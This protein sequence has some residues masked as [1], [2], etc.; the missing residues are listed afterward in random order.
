MIAWAKSKWEKAH[1]RKTIP[2]RLPNDMLLFT[3]SDRERI[4]AL[5]DRE[6]RVRRMVVHTRS[7]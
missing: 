5:I 6:N 2:L 3:N 7:S 1:G 4:D